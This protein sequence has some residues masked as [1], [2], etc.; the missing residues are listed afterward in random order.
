MQKSRHP[1]Q[2][3]VFIGKSKFQPRNFPATVN[4]FDSYPAALA[5]YS[6]RTVTIGRNGVSFISFR[7]ASTITPP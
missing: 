6:S 7:S 5:T 4:I 2:V 3:I 1:S